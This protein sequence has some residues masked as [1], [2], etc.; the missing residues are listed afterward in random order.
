MNWRRSLRIC[1]K[2]AGR[3]PLQFKEAFITPVIKKPSLDAADVRSYR[4]ISNL[5]V[6]SK[7]LERLVAGQLFSYPCSLQLF[8]SCHSG[9]RAGHSTETAVLRALSQL[10]QVVDNGEYAALFLLDLSA[11]FDT[12]HI[13]SCQSFPAE[14]RKLKTYLLK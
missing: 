3:F 10:L 14:H 1:S 4:P 2:F 9:F 5:S 12:D 11:A 6:V 8:P 7:L 13:T